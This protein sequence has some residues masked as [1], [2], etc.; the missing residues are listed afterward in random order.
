MRPRGW[1]SGEGTLSQCR[2]PDP[3]RFPYG[4]ADLVRYV[5]SKGLLF[6]I[7]TDVTTAPCT[8]G[9]Y[10]REHENVPGSYGHYDTDARTFAAWGVDGVKADFC[11]PK[12]PNGSKVDPE[13]AY[14]ELS[15][16]LNRCV[17]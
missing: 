17:L 2:Y 14:R 15:Q 3:T 8:H 1:D 13:V 10:E 6:S 16:A 4:I 5:H 11:N 9:Q 12:L 7:Y